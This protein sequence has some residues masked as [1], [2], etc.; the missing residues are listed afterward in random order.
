MFAE[1]AFKGL[2]LLL[3]FADA[4]AGGGQLGEQTVVADAVTR[5]WWPAVVVGGGLVD[6]GGEVVVS[7]EEVSVDAGAGDDGAS[8]DR[9]VFALQGL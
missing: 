8:G 5:R 7:V 3:E 4:V 6:L 1:T 2:D 9:A